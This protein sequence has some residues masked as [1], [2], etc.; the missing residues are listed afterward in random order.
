MQNWE[1]KTSFTSGARLLGLA[2]VLLTT[3][4]SQTNAGETERTST[5]RI[6]ILP[7]N[8]IVK[9]FTKYQPLQTYLQQHLHRKIEL[10]VPSSLQEFKRIIQFNETEFTFQAP[11]TYLKL[12]NQYEKENL[13]KSLTPEGNSMH[14]GVIITRKDSG[15]KN[16]TDLRGKNFLFGHLYSTTKWLAAKSLL[17]RNGI[18]PEKDLK[19][20][21]HGD[22]CESIAM[23]IYLGQNDAGVMC[24]YSFNEMAA[25]TS[26]KDDE[27]PP[28]GLVVIGTTWEI[29]TWVFA[30]RKGTN[31]ETV[32]QVTN[33]LLNLSQQRPEYSEILQKLG[34]G[35]FTR[36]KD[37]D[38]DSL[39]K[40]LNTPGSPR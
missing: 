9:T 30:A 13:L 31:Q 10:L 32:A 4:V 12:E 15:I 38:Y 11:H 17:E 28:D 29:P 33:A 35:G 34:L 26:P 27:I 3:L 24:D 36:A 1:H 19:D 5:I 40:N 2:L 23:N 6:A 16:I 21:S 14:H 39:R 25:N 8:D 18:N 7:C 20:Y 22:C 37:S